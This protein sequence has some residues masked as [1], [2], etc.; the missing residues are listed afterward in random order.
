MKGDAT[1]KVLH[2]H[3][4]ALFAQNRYPV[5]DFREVDVTN[6]RVRLGSQLTPHP[7][8]ILALYRCE[9]TG[10]FVGFTEHPETWRNPDYLTFAGWRSTRSC[11]F[12]D[13]MHLHRSD[14][15]VAFAW[16][17]LL[18]RCVS[19]LSPQVALSAS[20]QAIFHGPV[21][22]AARDALLESGLAAP[23]KDA[24]QFQVGPV[25]WVDD[26]DAMR[27]RVLRLAEYAG[28]GQLGA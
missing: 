27:E 10:V 8:R 28:V 19:A 1:T 9:N 2:K 22:P 6:R 21:S 23:R 16:V 17:A 11:V 24:G 15:A 7:P 20:L 25:T 26:M 13:V 4:R 5:F 18:C 3:R 12:P 14:E